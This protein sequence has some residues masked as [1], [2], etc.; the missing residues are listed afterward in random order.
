MRPLRAIVPMLRKE[1][2]VTLTREAVWRLWKPYRANRLLATI[3]RGE[4]NLRFRNVPYY[5]PK[6]GAIGD[7]NTR[8]IYGVSDM[9]CQGQFPFLGYPTTNMGFPPPWNRDFMNG[10]EWENVTSS[11]LHP[12]VRHN[13]S[14]VKTPWELSRLQFLPVLAK[15]HLLSND[16][17][18]RSAAKE[19]LSAWL[20]ENPVGMGVNWTLAMESAL[21][22]MSLCFVLSLLQPLQSDEQD[23]GRAVAHSIWEHLLYTEASLEFSHLMRSN[24]Y[25]GNIVGLLCM[26]TFLEGRGMDGRRRFYQRSVEDEIL[27]QVHEDGGDYEASL[28]YHV[29]V[30]QMF[31]SAFLLMHA[32]RSEPRNFFI[33]RLSQMH[34]FLAAIA[35]TQGCVPHV[36][37]CDDGRTELLT[38]DLKQ[39]L[40]TPL[41][42]RNSLRISSLLGLGNALFSTGRSMAGADLV[43]Y[44]L[45]VPK[46][47]G[48]RPNSAVFP[49]SGLAVARRGATEVVFCAI[50]NGIQGR[51]SHTHN[52][53]LSIIARIGAD[54]LFCDSGTFVYTRDVAVRNR[55]RSTAAHNTLMIDEQEQNTINLDRQFAFCIGNE[56][57]VSR[58][59]VQESA[60]EFCVSASHSGY[61]RIGV[62]HQRKVRVFA[63]GFTVEDELQG[64]GEH[65][66]ES[67]WHIPS[68]WRVLNTEDGFLIHGPRQVRFIVAAAIPVTREQAP[69][70]ISRTYGGATESGTVLTIKGKA[71]LP[72]GITTSVTWE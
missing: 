67:R 36:G 11:Q 19:L 64:T 48:S 23:W 43:W 54:E 20:H 66:F 7:L 63:H 56:A 8:V 31:T 37:D 27:R 47:K 25:L 10:F 32:A 51:G 57:R 45:E 42:N 26:S 62:E 50:P 68:C 18:Y 70:L 40:D 39:M 55:Y 58:I 44:G 22:G 14:D 12:V 30:L 15:A 72:C 69:T 34:K 29:L 6:V 35:D 52:D 3:R 33:E 71:Q 16:G 46:A 1:S 61:S 21:R 41:E 9:I 17:K 60:E 4:K 13:G 38:D 2:P 28:G 53:K 65:S 24:H 49:V 5:R 59:D